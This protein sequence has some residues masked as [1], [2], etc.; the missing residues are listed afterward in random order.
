MTLDSYPYGFSE[1]LEA[2]DAP[3]QREIA[4]NITQADR[5][6]LRNILLPNQD[7]RQALDTPMSV[8]KLFIVAQGSPATELAGTFL[9]SGPPGQRVFL[10]TPGFGL[11]PFDHREL[12]LK[13]LLERLSLAPQ[14][15][16]LLRFV[17]LRIK[18]AIRF[19]P[20]PTLVSEP[21]RGGVLIDRRQSIET[22]LDYSLKNLHDELL[23]LPTLKSLLSRLFENHLGQHFPHVNLTALRVIS[24]AT[25]LS[26]DGTATLPLTQLSTRLLSETLLEHYNRGAWPAGQ[27]REFI[28]PGY[29]SSATDTVVWEAA[30]ASLSGQLY[31]H[32]ESTLR[33][34]WKE[35]LDNGQPRQDLFIDAMGTRFR[36]ELLQQEQD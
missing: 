19:D 21:I 27:S 4:R 25:P 20:P 26:G 34:F 29:S 13:K 17:A 33:D 1:A 10:C 18:T 28:A 2:R 32:L 24:Y 9:V 6:W 35:P 3:N 5:T 12:A 36:A 30:L 23:R 31:S 22:Y 14:R 16:E 11:E 15:D 7:A 8:D